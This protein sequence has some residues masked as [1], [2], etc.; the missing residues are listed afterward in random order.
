[1]RV[2]GCFEWMKSGLLIAALAAGATACR[3]EPAA[4]PAADETQ[5]EAIRVRAAE[6]AAREDE[7][8]PKSYVV[9]KE[10][11][12]AFVRYQRR[13]HEVH[14]ALVRDTRRLMSRT[15]GGVKTAKESMRVLE[16]KAGAEQE[17]REELGLTPHDVRTLS[18]MAME[19]ASRRSLAK[20]LRLEDALAELEE[21]KARLG[22]ERQKELEEEIASVRAQQEA[23]SG[24]QGARAKWGDANIDLLLTRE[25]DLT[26]NYQ[27]MLELFGNK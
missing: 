15:D 25:A 14:G 19:V 10:K 20:S 11:L 7:A 16:S 8:D 17:A 22:P 21:A 9:T 26:K 1:M 18:A 6:E 5:L 13:M 2:H 27:A 24:L 12:D 4:G 23:L 3:E